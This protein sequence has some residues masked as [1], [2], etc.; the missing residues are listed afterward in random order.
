MPEL[1]RIEDYHIP[2]TVEETLE[3]LAAETKRGR[4]VALLAGG[5]DILV[6]MRE[7]RMQPRVIIQ[8]EAL[9]ELRGITET[10]TSLRIGAR[11]T[12]AELLAS[13]LIERHARV[14]S[15]ACF[16]IGAPQIQSRGTVGG[17]LGTASP[18]GDLIPPLL[19]LDA[20]VLC[21]SVDD[22]RRIPIGDFVKGVGK[23]DLRPDELILGVEFPKP[24]PGAHGLWHKMGP[25][26]AQSISKVSF[27]GLVHLDKRKRVALCRLAYGAVA[28]TAIR[29]RETE[30]LLTSQALT[31]AL[32]REAQA[33]VQTEFSPITDLRSTESYRRK[34]CGVMLRR[35]LSG[36]LEQG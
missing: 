31:P 17:Q 4:E 32:I 3:L 7:G 21:R 20:E 11:V 24:P 13:P 23:N 2:Q 34:M 9:D 22:E 33:L 27:A 35:G 30:A 25:R 18:V 8:I 14:I 36:L 16:E 6:R 15:L 19:V 10:E 12:F 5:T 1:V 26:R 29:A 28:V